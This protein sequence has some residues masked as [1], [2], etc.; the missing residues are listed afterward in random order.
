MNTMST[1][2]VTESKCATSSQRSY[3]ANLIA[4]RPSWAA[5]IG[6]APEEITN[7]SIAEA[8]KWIQAA[9]SITPEHNVERQQHPNA[10]PLDQLE[11]GSYW[12]L[13]GDVV[14]VRQSKRGHLYGEQ[15]DPNEGRFKYRPGIL[16]RLKAR[17]SLDEAK[18]WGA[19]F[20]RCCVCAKLLITEKSVEQGIG[21]V[22]ARSLLHS[23]TTRRRKGRRS[24]TR[25]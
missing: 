8:S 16:F 10:I 1:D 18:E 20:G 7:L 4:E 2:L 11:E 14:R 23:S 12:S 19:R 21:P 6:L 24:G 17:M 22:C 9:V 25:Y 15:L 13:D 3:L 5:A